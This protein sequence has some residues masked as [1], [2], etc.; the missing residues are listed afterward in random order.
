VNGSLA[1]LVS[2]AQ[3]ALIDNAEGSYK[4]G[5]ALI[6]EPAHLPLQGEALL[7]PDAG[8]SPF[9]P[10]I[11]W[12]LAGAPGPYAQFVAPAQ[13]A[14]LTIK[15]APSTFTL[16]TQHFGTKGVEIDAAGLNG[17]L[18]T[19]ILGDS[20]A[21]ES[22]GIVFVNGYS[23]LNIVNNGPGTDILKGLVLESP[24]GPP[25]SLPAIMEAAAAS[26][27]DLVFSGNNLVISGSLDLFLGD[28]APA[29]G[30]EG[31]HVSISAATIT[32]HGV[33]LELGTIATFKIDASDAPF[34]V[35]AAPA[36]PIFLNR[37]ATGVTVLGGPGPN[38]L[39]GSLDLVSK[40]TFSNGSTGVAATGFV[41]A[42][43]ITGGSG[44]V[45]TIFGDGGA[46][47][48]T[49]PNHSLPDTVVFG[50]DAMGDTNDVLAITDGNDVAFLGS[51]GASA[52]AV[53]IPALF[54]GSITGGTSADMTVITGF[55]AVPAG[56]VL[57]FELAAWNGD[58]FGIPPFMSAVTG[59]LV[60]LNGLFVPKPGDAELS[61]VWVNSGSN[62]DG[63]LATSD[64]VLR[65][66]PSDASVQNA[67]Q[68]AA[69]LHTSSDAI[70][71]P[72]GGAGS[73][74]IAPGKHLH[75][76]VA[77][78]AGNNVV[79]VADVDLVNTSASDQ[80]STANLN[81]YASDMVNLTGVSLAGLTTHIH[82][83]S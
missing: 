70:V 48:I 16:N 1:L 56:D 42:D 2:E 26:S 38:Q 22:L 46:D 68:L 80:S 15:N 79:N 9:G 4:A 45:D 49:L 30:T 35:M 29:A 39:Q 7:I 83:I 81:V 25:Q 31:N 78:A 66:A 6:A 8:G 41:G 55:R 71:L 28:I 17:S 73:G 27:S 57:D 72:G 75:I 33:A 77:Y 76:L 44:G 63:S 67:Q 14:D 43:H 23:T 60:A 13:T 59:D 74:F 62:S 65:Y 12:A 3:N 20:A 54:S 37:A 24:F 47:V 19:L 64:E 18:F 52:T 21:S 32:D 50:Q 34:L 69:Q 40:V 5:I 51:W 11:D 82:F 10:T 61:A 53:T 36:D 58:S